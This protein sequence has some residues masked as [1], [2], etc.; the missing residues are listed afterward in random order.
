MRSA[1]SSTMYLTPERSQEPS[2]IRV[3]NHRNSDVVSRVSMSTTAHE[4]AKVTKLDQRVGKRSALTRDNTPG[5]TEA[6]PSRGVNT[7]PV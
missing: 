6:S 7:P 1:S 4:Q 5:L 3:T 2:C